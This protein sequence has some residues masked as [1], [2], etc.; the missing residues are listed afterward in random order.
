MI[1]MKEPKIKIKTITLRYL[2]VK[3]D[4]RGTRIVADEKWY[5]DGC[6]ADLGKKP[7]TMWI[8]VRHFLL[9]VTKAGNPI[10]T[11]KREVVEIKG[12]AHADMVEKL[13][14]V[15]NKME[16]CVRKDVKKDWIPENFIELKNAIKSGAL[17]V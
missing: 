1:E 3:P 15:T 13:D 4:S 6:L 11:K 8:F 7:K 9:K 14:E 10:L 12:K 2:D 5:E 16:G 17:R